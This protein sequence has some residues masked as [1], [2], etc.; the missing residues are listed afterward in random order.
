MVSRC[1]SSLWI[2]EW[3]ALTSNEVV[4]PYSQCFC[5]TNALCIYL[6]VTRGH[7]VS[8]DY[9][10]KPPLPHGDPFHFL[11]SLFLPWERPCAEC[12]IC[13]EFNFQS[14]KQRSVLITKRQKIWKKLHLPIPSL[15]WLMPWTHWSSL[16]YC[17]IMLLPGRLRHQH[18]SPSSFPGEA[19]RC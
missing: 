6:F 16:P 15:Q 10:P 13:D 2:R 4:F 12:G 9:P 17:H 18:V 3:E 11:L 19:M 5:S 14:K 1:C 8:P 7:P